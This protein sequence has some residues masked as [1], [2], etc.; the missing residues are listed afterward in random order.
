MAVT[1]YKLLAQGHFM[2]A[3]SLLSV[4]EAAA[5]LNLKP[6]WVRRLCLQG[7]LAGAHKIGRDWLIPEQSVI[8][9]AKVPRKVGRPKES[10]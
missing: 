3:H 4:P 1:I 7:R 8:E 5:R 9:F 2:S 10:E 6:A